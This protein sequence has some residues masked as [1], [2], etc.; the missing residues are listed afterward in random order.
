MLSQKGASQQQTDY[1]TEQCTVRE[2]ERRSVEGRGRE[3]RERR[4]GQEANHT[5]TCSVKKHKTSD[6]VNCQLL[7]LL[8][9]QAMP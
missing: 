3:G 9:F 8:D 5:Y 7:P 2:K 6:L 1:A 4:K